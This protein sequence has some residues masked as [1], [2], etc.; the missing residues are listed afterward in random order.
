MPRRYQKNEELYRLC[1]ASTTPCPGRSRAPQGIFPLR[2]P[3]W[4]CGF[5]G[6]VDGFVIPS[7]RESHGCDVG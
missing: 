2:D 4:V 1:L 7:L 6:Q 5:G 3:L